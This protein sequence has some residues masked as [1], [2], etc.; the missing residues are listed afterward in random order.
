M[1]NYKTARTATHVSISDALMVG[2]FEQEAPAKVINL[3]G[4]SDLSEP[5]PEASRDTAPQKTPLFRR[6]LA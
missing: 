5:S 3:D 1:M 4:D 6:F 2:L